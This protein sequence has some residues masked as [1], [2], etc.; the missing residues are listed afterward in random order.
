MRIAM[1]VCAS[2]LPGLAFATLPP[3]SDEAKV[4]AAETAAKT[5]W[6]DKVA[7]Y[8][9][10]VASDRTAAEYRS[11]L[12]AAGKDVPPPV[13]TPPCTDP[14]PYVAHMTPSTSKPL[15]AAGAHSPSGPA[16]SPPNTKATAKE[17]SEFARN[18][19]GSTAR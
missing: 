3:P 7:L 4:K 2:C 18:A 5:A 8:K 14:G 6:D 1:V 15:E 12:K 17:I 10:C 13:A 11:G 16:A 19:G 9:L